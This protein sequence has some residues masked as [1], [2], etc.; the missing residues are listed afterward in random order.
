MDKL[1]GSSNR[2]PAN[3]A[4]RPRRGRP[5]RLSR[6][7]VVAA[8]VTLAENE[9]QAQVTMARVAEAVGATP[10]AVYRYVPN[11]EVLL[12]EVNNALIEQM[13]FEVPDNEPWQQR[14]RLW[15]DRAR[16]HF[17]ACPEAM[18]QIGSPQSSSPAWM[19]AIAPL[20]E[21]LR[22]AGFS[23][24]STALGVVWVARLTMGVLVQEVSGPLSQEHF[25]NTFSRLEADQMQLW[26]SLAPELNAVGNDR[27]FEFVKTQAIDAL[28]S[29]VPDAS[30][31]SPT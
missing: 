14:I 7:K 9:G 22:G 10:M 30:V 21:T 23:D 29:L 17:V 11:R 2:I 27:F 5:P 15:M 18:A 19:K 24:E 13:D 26:L 4:T 31:S 20:A 16:A 28:S 3:A 25:A 8:A 6:E 1:I 12:A